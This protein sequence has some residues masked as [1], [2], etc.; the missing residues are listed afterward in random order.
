MF[1]AGVGAAVVDAGVGLGT[2]G[3]CPAPDDTHLVETYMP[4]ETVIV[5]PTRHC[6]Y[7]ILKR[8]SVCQHGES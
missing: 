6:K 4:Q 1:S 2:V 5:N 8:K 7:K 3:V